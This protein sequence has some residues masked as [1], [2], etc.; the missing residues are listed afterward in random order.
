MIHFRVWRSHFKRKDPQQ[1]SRPPTAEYRVSDTTEVIELDLDEYLATPSA[2]ASPCLSFRSSFRSGVFDIDSVVDHGDDAGI[3]TH[4]K[5]SGLESFTACNALGLQGHPPLTM[6]DADG[7]PRA[8]F[9]PD[10]CAPHIQ[11][12]VYTPRLWASVAY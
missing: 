4:A 8:S 5:T 11:F 6:V 9:S 12:E 7:V 2:L 1:V 3:V 10:F